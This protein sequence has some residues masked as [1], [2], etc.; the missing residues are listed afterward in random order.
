MAESCA[1]SDHGEL[2]GEFPRWRHY[3]EKRERKQTQKDRSR[4]KFAYRAAWDSGGVL[5][6]EAAFLPALLFA[7]H[8]ALIISEIRLRQAAL[9]RLGFACGF[10]IGFPNQ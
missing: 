2:T 6:G 7:A 5:S 10:S 4:R 9:S 1:D 3:A 8:R